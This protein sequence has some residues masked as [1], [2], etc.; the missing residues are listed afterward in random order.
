MIII[1]VTLHLTDYLN[2]TLWFG[3]KIIK[4]SSAQKDAAMSCFLIITSP[5]EFV[6]SDTS[7]IQFLDYYQ[8]SISKVSNLQTYIHFM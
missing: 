4:L 3:L 8:P 1:T 5:I 2:N 7:R 6:K